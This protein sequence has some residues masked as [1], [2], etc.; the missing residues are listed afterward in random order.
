VPDTGVRVV[1]LLAAGLSDFLD[2]WWARHRGPR[3]RA[4]AMLDPITDKAF[5][6]TALVAFAVDGTLSLAGL[7]VLLARDACVAFG[8]LLL[9]ALRAPARFEAR[10]PGKL[11]TNLQLAAVLVLLLVPS[12]TLPLVVLTGAASVWAIADYGRIG[13]RALRARTG[14]G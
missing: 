1:V 13:V 9:L 14:P 7:A 12:L 2:G 11:V 8:F 4:G 5:V 3:T 10:F 6:I